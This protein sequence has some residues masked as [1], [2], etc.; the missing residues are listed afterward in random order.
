MHDT[1]LRTQT[2]RL[3]HRMAALRIN[4]LEGTCDF[5]FGHCPLVHA[6]GGDD[7]HDDDGGHGDGGD[8]RNWPNHGGGSHGGDGDPSGEGG[9]IPPGKGF[10]N[11]LGNPPNNGGVHSSSPSSSN[12]SSSGSP[13][14][15][16]TTDS[17][18]NIVGEVTAAAIGETA[19]AGTLTTMSVDPTLKPTTVPPS[20]SSTT[21][22][23]PGGTAISPSSSASILIPEGGISTALT[24]QSTPTGPPSIEASS[25]ISTSSTTLLSSP[26][27]TQE[28]ISTT[29][30]SNS[31][32]PGG[33]AGQSQNGGSSSS[34]ASSTNAPAIAGG[35]V[36][37][38]AL[39]L[40]L[41]LGAW[42]L[43]RRRE[44][45]RMFDTSP[46]TFKND[47]RGSSSS[48]DLESHVTVDLRSGPDPSIL[49]S[50][51]SGGN[52][53]NNSSGDGLSM[54]TVP[55]PAGVAVAAVRNTSASSS[56]PLSPRSGS[57]SQA[58]LQSATQRSWP[59]GGSPTSSHSS[60]EEAYAMGTGIAIPYGPEQDQRRSQWQAYTPLGPQG[61]QS[62]PMPNIPMLQQQ[63]LPGGAGG[64]YGRPD[65]PQMSGAIPPII[66]TPGFAPLGVPVAGLGPVPRPRP[67]TLE[68]DGR[69][70]PP[71]YP[72]GAPTGTRGD[73]N[74][75][76]ML[77][78]NRSINSSS[79][80]PVSPLSDT[81]PVAFSP[82]A[83]QDPLHYP[84][85]SG[86][87]PGPGGVA[88]TAGGGSHYAQK[89]QV[90]LGPSY[91]KY[92]PASLPEVVA[93]SPM[94]QLGHVAASPP[95]Y[96]DSAERGGNQND[97]NGPR[98]PQG[99]SSANDAKAALSSQEP[100]RRY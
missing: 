91:G 44:R 47:S 69:Q 94:M 76:T 88:G 20:F 52:L 24:T 16:S 62:M 10:G 1:T 61:H 73:V 75:N 6:Q 14:S 15:D 60:F 79:P 11:S 53:G 18:T 30:S 26:T 45:N 51:S 41:L 27:S 29:S 43:R 22:P 33:T 36:G 34:K 74:T 7:G 13:S 97:R 80:L 99:T 92:D 49:S 96:D 78:P 82:N 68:L 85:M 21:A 9:P 55:F 38:L 100:I 46:K 90:P 3:A 2:L 57:D 12:P 42:Y 95:E 31:S 28:P 54:A 65:L 4:L 89:S 5:L 86:I 8:P 48:G 17:S 37:G 81:S 58:E 39:V 93:L 40:L 59:N 70:P 32:S 98:D 87:G 56:T 72:G 83:I 50:S 71:Q 77:S 64:V 19:S 66:S 84:N 67:E 35:V 23:K 25:T 63:F